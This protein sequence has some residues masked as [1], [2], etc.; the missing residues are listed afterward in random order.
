MGFNLDY[1]NSCIEITSPTV[2]V[3]AQTLHDFIEDQMASPIGLQHPDIIQPEGKIEDQS[4][5]GVFSQIIMVINSPWQIQFWP[6]SGY[7]TIFGGKIVGGLSDQPVKATGTAG[8]LTVL[9]SPVDGVTVVTGS[10]LT[11]LQDTRLK[12]AWD[13]L[14]GKNVVNRSTGML[15]VYDAAGVLLYVAPIF[16]DAAGLTPVGAA[17]TKIDRRDRLT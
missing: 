8:D 16:E 6:G 7:T 10:A 13:I 17:S 1:A 5:P 15:E 2:S 14:R 11:T 12:D 4:N 9:N 3:D